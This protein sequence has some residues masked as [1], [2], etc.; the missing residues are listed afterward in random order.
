M[1]CVLD[2]D[3]TLIDSFARHGLLLEELL[4]KYAVDAHVRTAD[5]M[6]YKRS[7]NNNYKYLTERLGLPEAAA[8]KICREWIQRIED[9][10][11]LQYDKLYDDALSFLRLVKLHGDEIIFLSARHNDASAY[12]E[13]IRLGIS[14]YAADIDFVSQFAKY[15]TKTACI[16]HL[17]S[18]SARPPLSALPKCDIIVIGDTED[19]FNAALANQVP[20]LILSRGFRSSEYLTKT[21]KISKCFTNLTEVSKKIYE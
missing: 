12:D 4:Q 17:L 15:S 7:G 21:L 10:F 9:P 2:L 13:V 1:I 11:W 3:G 16:K 8:C 18:V 5:Y 14:Q 19:E 6:E 20:S